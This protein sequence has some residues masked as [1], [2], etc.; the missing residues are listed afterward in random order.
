MVSK[1]LQIVRGF[2]YE[3]DSNVSA[4]DDCRTPIVEENRSASNQPLIDVEDVS[5]DGEVQ[6]DSN[7]DRSTSGYD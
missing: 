5:T 2:R 1:V 7:V 6:P 3:T 4:I